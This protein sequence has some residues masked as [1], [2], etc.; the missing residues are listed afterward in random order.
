MK[1]QGKTIFGLIFLGENVSLTNVNVNYSF[2]NFKTYWNIAAF[3]LKSLYYWPVLLLKLN[4]LCKLNYCK[5]NSGTQV[6][7]YESNRCHLYENKSW[8]EMRRWW[9]AWTEGE[10]SRLVVF[11]RRIQELR[12]ETVWVHGMVVNEL[13]QSVE[14]A[15]RCHVHLP[16]K[17]LLHHGE[18]R[19]L[20][21]VETVKI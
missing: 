19:G 14:L 18:E 5:R 3:L 2:F 6:R 11:R 20:L 7:L 8:F 13:C 12:D 16:H 1:K 21:S 9:L 17:H 15:L 10:D 4:W